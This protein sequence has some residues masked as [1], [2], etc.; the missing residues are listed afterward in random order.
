MVSRE[1]MAISF[2]LS[3]VSNPISIPPD[4]GGG[5]NFVF[6]CGGGDSFP[7]VFPKVPPM[8]MVCRHLQQ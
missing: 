8:Q 2:Q 5:G 4:G 6:C 3:A 1:D 7:Q